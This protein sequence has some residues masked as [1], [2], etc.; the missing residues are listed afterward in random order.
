M[1]TGSPSLAFVH[2]PQTQHTQLAATRAPRGVELSDIHPKRHMDMDDGD[3]DGCPW[4]TPD[5]KS[6]RT[7]TFRVNG[8]TLQISQRPQLTRDELFATGSGSVV[9][10]AAD[11]LLAHL[12]SS[13]SVQGAFVVELGA[14]TGVAGLAC[15]ALMADRVVLTDLQT[16]IPLLQ[17][18]ATHALAQ[19]WCS[20]AHQ[21]KLEVRELSWG[22]LEG[23]ES[24]ASPD[25][26]IC[27]DLLYQPA[28]YP[29]LAE[30]IRALR[31]KRTLL[32]WQP[33]GK[34]EETFVEMLRDSGYT[35]EDVATV[36]DGHLQQQQA[37]RL[38]YLSPPS[39]A[40]ATSPCD[41]APAPVNGAGNALD[42]MVA[43]VESRSAK[44]VKDELKARGWL[45]AGFHP[46]NLS[47]GQIAFP[48]VEA[49]LDDAQRAIDDAAGGGPSSALSA[50]IRVQR[51]QMVAKKPPAPQKR[52]S[53]AAKA[54]AASRGLAAATATTAATT[55]T[56]TTITTTKT[57]PP[58]SRPSAASSAHQPRSF[59][60]G[61]ALRKA[62]AGDNGELGSG[63]MLPPAPPIRHVV[64]DPET[65]DYQWLQ[66]EVFRLGEPAVLK[67]LPLGAC[68]GGWTAARLARARCTAPSV[69]VHV[70]ESPTVDLAG[71]RPPNTPRNFVFRSMPFGEAVER[72]S[73]ASAVRE[74][75][76]GGGGESERTA[77]HAPL[78][79]AGERYYLRSVGLDPRR[80]PADFPTLFP[81]LAEECTLLPP[82]H[83]QQSPAAPAGAASPLLDPSLYH[84]SVLRLASDD[85][86][87]WT[88]FDVMD[89]ALA[90][91][92]GR[93]RVVMWPPTE[94][95]N[96]YV[97]GSSSRVADIDAW[98]DV[99]FP[100][101]RRSVHARRECELGPGDVLYIPALWF[102]NVTSI[103]FSVALNVFW[104][105]HPAKGLHSP[106]DLYGNKDP[107]V[108]TQ[109]LELTDAAAETIAALPEPFRSFYARRA[110]RK[111]L[112]RCG[113]VGRGASMYASVAPS[114]V[115]CAALLA[116]H[117]HV[118]ASGH[119]IP[120]VGL[121]LYEMAP[122]DTVAA[123]EAALRCGIRHID[124][125]AA[126]RNEAEVGVAL[127]RALADGAIAR[128]DV[129]VTSKLWNSDHTRVRAAC[130]RSLAALQLDYLDAY[131]VHWPPRE[132]SSFLRT[133][134]A[135]EALVADGLVRSIG[136]SNC[137][138]S[139]LQ[140]LLDAAPAIAPAINQIE[141]HPG[142]HNAE[143]RA[144]CARANV[145]VTSYAPFAR[146]ELLSDPAVLELAQSLGTAPTQILLRWCLAQGGSAVFKSRRADRIS[147]N[148]AGLFAPPAKA[149]DGSGAAALLSG[150]QL[151]PIGGLPQSRRVLGSGFVATRVKEGATRG[152]HQYTSLEE[153]WS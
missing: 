8:A 51:V 41:A 119:S 89:N 130:L 58:A 4:Q 52:P 27:C 11:Q 84:S 109:A 127:H 125:A 110:A 74:G 30:T 60:G 94:D 18:N 61:G 103:G 7:R 134:Q 70:C 16:E 78:L 44:G 40:D 118:L 102:H 126:Y 86:Q 24:L 92:T 114:S 72:C 81:E 37:V 55:T 139:K 13:S 1:K 107:P 17:E 54:L 45:D 65:V 10:E 63:G 137:S 36:G 53:P 150:E 5:A 128:S 131:L 151:R 123:V 99:E 34:S 73:G 91:L 96:L 38:M 39:T 3:E 111:V 31:P 122:A 116:E 67:G 104:R 64:C 97:D 138:A 132:T 32:A 143:L 50:V 25:L 100:L 129:F 59:G 23:I 15:A 57:K 68:V 66:Q 95:D 47:D 136:V 77:A 82:R 85:T 48:L 71:H 33:R 142:F 79:R 149:P 9:W 6:E 147:Q 29:A 2:T 12:E 80:D 75:G 115:A 152:Q 35:T 108:A 120:L 113:V 42:R 93:K 153:L 90:Q 88:H 105:S 62:L 145:H 46:L 83:P 106:K 21:C 20:G 14:G 117:R 121:G 87:L 49:H 101:Y 140:A 22:A 144:A 124:C 56:T 135:M 98:N 133:W 26:C 19:P 76:G 69:S 43:V 148:V 146:G 28:N 112:E 141:S